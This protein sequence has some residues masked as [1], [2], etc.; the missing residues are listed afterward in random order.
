MTIV[1]GKGI[2]ILSGTNTHANI[3]TI[4][5]IGTNSNT[6]SLSIASDASLGTGTLTLNGTA[7]ILNITGA[8]TIDNAILFNQNAT[9]SA[10][11]AVTLSGVISGTGAL[12]KSGTG[13]LTLSGN[14]ADYSGNI[15]LNVG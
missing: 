10:T 9:I 1:Y 11:N 5:G 15:A 8:T 4:S 14:N 7:A 13:V 3:F 6:N 2:A 12:T